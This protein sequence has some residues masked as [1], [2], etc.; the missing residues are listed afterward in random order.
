MVVNMKHKPVRYVSEHIGLPAD[1]VCGASIITAYGNN[2]VFIENYRG[3]TEYNDKY[4]KIQGKNCRIIIKGEH[5][6]I[7]FYTDNDMRID[8]IIN[9][10][11]FYGG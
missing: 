6:V 2:H 7:N 9:D 4:I 11:N 1:I 5:L 3:I 10:V 8:G